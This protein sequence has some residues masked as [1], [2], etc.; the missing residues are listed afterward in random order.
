[1]L[2]SHTYLLCS[3][4]DPAINAVEPMSLATTTS[5]ALL[6]VLQ[7]SLSGET[8]VAQCQPQVVYM[9]F[10]IAVGFMCTLRGLK[11]MAGTVTKSLDTQIALHSCSEAL[12]RMAETWPLAKKY[13]RA[14]K[15][16]MDAERLESLESRSTAQRDS[17]VVE[18]GDRRTQAAEPSRSD[19]ITQQ[20]GTSLS[21]PT[22]GMNDMTF[23]TQPANHQPFLP[24]SVG[25]LLEQFPSFEDITGTT[26]WGTENLDNFDFSGIPFDRNDPGFDP[27]LSAFLSSFAAVPGVPFPTNNFGP[28]NSSQPPPFAPSYG[29]LPPNHSLREEGAQPYNAEHMP[30]HALDLLAYS[31]VNR[32]TK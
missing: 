12:S 22:N 16:L 7:N 31:A 11:D 19:R 1:M 25:A 15:V 17:A 9:I 20:V 8:T 23:N 30:G 28:H 4:E 27:E 24:T 29:G 18:P 14:V 26:G 32:Q 3:Q 13:G 2:T 10:T 6:Y 21:G 5:K